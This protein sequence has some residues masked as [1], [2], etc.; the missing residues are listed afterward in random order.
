M[1]IRLP[2][3]LSALVP[4]LLFIGCTKR[5]NYVTT[6]GFAGYVILDAN[7]VLAAIGKYTEYDIDGFMV[8]RTQKENEYRFYILDITSPG[9]IP[10]PLKSIARE[11][12]REAFPEG[13][14]VILDYWQILNVSDDKLIPFGFD[15]KDLRKPEEVRYF[16]IDSYSPGPEPGTYLIEAVAHPK[17]TRDT[18]KQWF[19]YDR[20]TR[21]NRLVANGVDYKLHD[22]AYSD[23]VAWALYR[24]DSTRVLF[25]PLG[26]DSGGTVITLPDTLK[27]VGAEAD[28]SRIGSELWVHFRACDCGRFPRDWYRRAGKD[29]AEWILPDEPPAEGIVPDLIVEVGPTRKSYLISRNGSPDEIH[30]FDLSP[31]FR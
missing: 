12:L 8:S 3:M 16:E 27:G 28:L 14:E 2:I 15:I 31:Y 25:R 29:T 18:Y 20:H 30:E 26:M 4:L 19:L 17:D 5:S 9:S 11:G 24:G 22:V 10:K 13:E 1:L 23:T 21:A 6:F 7:R